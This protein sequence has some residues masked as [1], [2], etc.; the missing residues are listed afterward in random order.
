MDSTDLMCAVCLRGINQGMVNVHPNNGGA[1][2]LTPHNLYDALNN[3][4]IR[5]FRTLD[6]A[7]LMLLAC[8]IAHNETR[9]PMHLQKAA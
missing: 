3:Y 6:D 2:P 1:F 4:G 8:T 5:A 9:C 7:P